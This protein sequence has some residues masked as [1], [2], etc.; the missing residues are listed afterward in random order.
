MSTKGYTGCG[1]SSGSGYCW[2]WNDLGQLGVGFFTPRSAQHA[3]PQ[4]V[5][6]SFTFTSISVGV[7]HTCALTTSGIPYCWG[8]NDHGQLGNETRT[9]S[10]VPVPVLP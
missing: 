2:G 7:W 1:I 3:T 9:N 10:A 4:R 5:L 8:L 6:G